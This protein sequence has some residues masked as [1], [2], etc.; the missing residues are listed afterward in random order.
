MRCGAASLSSQKPP[1]SCLSGMTRL[2]PDQFLHDRREP[3]QGPLGQSPDSIKIALVDG[4]IVP[5]TLLARAAE[6]IE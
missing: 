4:I 6:V 3:V 1:A 5:P 2:E